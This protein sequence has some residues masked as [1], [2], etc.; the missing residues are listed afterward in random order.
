MKKV[1]EEWMKNGSENRLNMLPVG[2]GVGHSMAEEAS[3]EVAK[4]VLD[5][6]NKF[7]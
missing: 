6:Y 7:A 1:W 2:G 3:E 4:A 5:F